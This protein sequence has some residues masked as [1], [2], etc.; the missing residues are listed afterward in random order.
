MQKI[1][2]V[3]PDIRYKVLFALARYAGLRVPSESPSWDQ[4]NIEVARMT[5]RSPKT[6]RHAGHEVARSA[7]RPEADAD[8]VGGVQCIAPEGEQRVCWTGWSGRIHTMA[9]TIVDR[10][11][12][13]AGR[14][15]SKP[16]SSCQWD[17]AA[18][19]AIRGEQVDRSF[20]LSERQ[21]LR[22][23]G[24]RT[25]FHAVAGGNDGQGKPVGQMD[26]RPAIRV[27]LTGIQSTP[28]TIFR[29]IPLNS[30]RRKWEQRDSNPQ[31]RDYESPALTIELCSQRVGTL[32][33]LKRGLGSLSI[34]RGCGRAAGRAR[35][36]GRLRRSAG[37]GSCRPAGAHRTR[38][39][40]TH[41]S[42][43]G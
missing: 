28:C 38:V 35:F 41:G 10:S 25:A 34:H 18:A 8:P 19:A 23:P 15:C 39:Q 36:F 30:S 32:G 12:W 21:A 29:A 1:F 31:P 26:V 20:H 24:D 40:V 17:C 27:E 6:E 42:R 9:R 3:C 33:A 13:N 2:A 11:G 14:I 16:L 4:V 22:Q 5:I 37:V 43:H 7:H